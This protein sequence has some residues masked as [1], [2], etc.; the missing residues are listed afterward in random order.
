MRTSSLIPLP[1]LSVRA[2]GAF[3]L[4]PGSR[5]LVEPG[6]HEL[7]S[8]GRRLAEQ[9][10]PSTG[11]ALPVLITGQA[12]SPGDVILT[13]LGS[14][15]V[16]G[17]EGYELTVTPEHVRIA[18]PC[19]A[20]V[21]RGMQTQRQ[22]LAPSVE[23]PEPQPGPWLIPAV[24]VRDK[25]RFP[26]RGFMLDV[27][28]H[29]F[30]VDE[31]KR[32]IDLLAAYKM[33]VL[34]LHLTDDQG[35]R[36]EIRSWPR[37]AEVGGSTA[38]GGGRGGFYTQ[39]EYA[40]LVVYAQA[41]YV[42]VVPEIDIPGHTGAALASYAELNAD[43]TAPPL[44]TGTEVGRTALCTGEEVTYRFVGDVLRELAALTPG[45]YLHIG[46]D[47]AFLTD[48]EE[49]RSFIER[50]QAMVQDQGKRMVGT[51]EIAQAC[52]L[53]ATAVLH[54][55]SG[56]ATQAVPQGA[57]VIMGPATRAYLD[58]KYDA[59]TALGLDWAGHVEVP[60]AYAWDPATQLP[61]IGE[62]DVLGVEALLW[63]ETV[64]GHADLETMALPRLLGI[65]EI[66]WSPAAARSWEEY[67]LRLAAHGPRLEAMG[68]QFYRSPAVP[69]E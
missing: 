26:W 16:L 27:A 29:F 8:I 42:T 40:E 41:R 10:R 55:A 25:P 6:L 34:H 65:A 43:G 33:N 68:R 59:S 21:F 22:L 35:W 58:M 61:G 11:Y 13:T 69:W 9:L 24:T 30:G 2:E 14:D 31:V 37:L 20:G 66:G 36:I 52:L 28:R 57:K 18:A 12:P 3:A 32:V 56:L 67:R 62:D 50:V 38:V 7:A 54:W 44:Y 51:E 17:D 23:R 5:I 60:D 53:P 64:S 15:A 45:P 1:V 48:P 63:T 4:L 47:E 39:E 19:A 49:Y 46:G